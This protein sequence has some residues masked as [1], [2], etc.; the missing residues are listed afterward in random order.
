MGRSYFVPLLVLAGILITAGWLGVHAASVAP[1]RGRQLTIEYVNSARQ[2][3]DDQIHF[4]QSLRDE[5]AALQK[6]HAWLE[7]LSVVFMGLIFTFWAFDRWAMQGRYGMVEPGAARA[8]GRLADLRNLAFGVLL[9]VMAVAAL[10]Y[11][12]FLVPDWLDTAKWKSDQMKVERIRKTLLQHGIAAESISYWRKPVSYT[13]V[14][15]GP[16]VND[17]HA[18][19]ETPATDLF[20]RNTSVTDLSPLK[21]SKITFLHLEGGLVSDL[22]PLAGM[23]ATY[24]CLRDTKVTDLAPLKTS[25]VEHLILEG[26]AIRDVSSLAGIRVKFLDLRGAEVSDLHPLAQMPCLRSVGLTRTQILAN[27]DVLKNLDVEVQETHGGPTFHPKSSAWQKQYEGVG[28]E[29]PQPH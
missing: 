27:L 4:V 17:I 3:P 18:I 24:L 14:L 1:G 15:Q 29:N 28:T 12:R 8:K 20:L 19:A 13:I 2:N 16:E 7:A 23:P 21:R 10:I 5:I 26:G 9:V 25:A 6:K 11:L 22:S